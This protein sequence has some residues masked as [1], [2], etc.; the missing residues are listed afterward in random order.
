MACKTY[1]EGVQVGCVVKGGVQDVDEGNNSCSPKFKHDLCSYIKTLVAA[2]KKIG[3]KEAEE[4][5]SLS[6]KETSLPAAPRPVSP[7]YSYYG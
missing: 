3:A 7:Y 4:F 1:I 2:F 6:V 5:L